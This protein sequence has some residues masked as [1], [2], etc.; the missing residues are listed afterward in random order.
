MGKY[1]RRTPLQWLA[2]RCRVCA[3][4]AAAGDT[5][6]AVPMLVLLLASALAQ[7]EAAR[8]ALVRLRRL[9]QAHYDVDPYIYV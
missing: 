3:D 8:A 7:Q 1:R 2:W 6:V 9:A 4:A 5:V